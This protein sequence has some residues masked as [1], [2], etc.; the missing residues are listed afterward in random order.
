MKTCR[1]PWAPPAAWLPRRPPL[2][3]WQRGRQH[4]DL[5]RN[6]LVVDGVPVMVLIQV[7]DRTTVVK[8]AE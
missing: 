2:T 8:A 3:D 6:S 4:R 7:V 1:E 5:R